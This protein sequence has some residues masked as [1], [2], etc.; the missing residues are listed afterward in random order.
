VLD[1]TNPVTGTMKWIEEL[2]QEEG[3]AT[4]KPWNAWQ[5]GDVNGGDVWVLRGLTVVTVRSAG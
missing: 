2:R 4:L 5:M 3:L 1:S